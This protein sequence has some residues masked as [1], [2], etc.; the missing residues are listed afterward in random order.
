MDS[1]HNMDSLHRMDNRN[2]NKVF[3]KTDNNTCH[4]PFVFVIKKQACLGQTSLLVYCLITS[5]NRPNP[6]LG[7]HNRSRPIRRSRDNRFLLLGKDDR[8]RHKILKT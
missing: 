7:S 5:S 8:S 4:A 6:S 3:Y 1:R 2:H